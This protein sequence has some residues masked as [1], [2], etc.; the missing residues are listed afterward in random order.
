ME[1]NERQAGRASYGLG[2]AWGEDTVLLIPQ[3][4][5]HV[6]NSWLPLLLFLVSES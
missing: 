5:E 4:L 2:R 3:W 6:E 1:R